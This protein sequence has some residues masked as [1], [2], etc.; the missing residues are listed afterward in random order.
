[1][2]RFFYHYNK[3]A[4]QKWGRPMLTVHWQGKCHLVGGVFC[5]VPT[6]TH[7]R[8]TQPRCVVRG[9]AKSVTFEGSVA[10]IA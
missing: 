2:R 4:S 6:E 7:I 10:V 1:M 5:Y 9:K 8:S 3:P